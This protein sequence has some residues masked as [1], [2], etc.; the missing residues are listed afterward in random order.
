LQLQRR[1]GL[2]QQS[3][4]LSE[5]GR[6]FQ[7]LDQHRELRRLRASLST[8]LRVQLGQLR[9]LGRSE[10]QRWLERYVLERAVRVRRRDLSRGAALPAERDL[11]LSGFSP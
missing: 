11:R 4:L 3:G 10:L 5:P 6:L 1:L 2:R 8:E 9:L 7:S